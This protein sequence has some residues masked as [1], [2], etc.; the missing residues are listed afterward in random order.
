[1]EDVD[2]G[3]HQELEV[4]KNAQDVKTGWTYEQT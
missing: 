1:V 4:Q 2:I 3:G